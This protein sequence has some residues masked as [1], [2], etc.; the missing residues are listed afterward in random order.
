MEKEMENKSMVKKII[1]KMENKS[2]MVKII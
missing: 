1:Y 2:M